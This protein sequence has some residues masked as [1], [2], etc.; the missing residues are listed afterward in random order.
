[1]ASVIVESPQALGDTYEELVANLDALAS[2]ELLL[3]IVP[4]A[5]RPPSSPKR[6]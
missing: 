5:H 2:A 3:S 1:M 6:G 4:P